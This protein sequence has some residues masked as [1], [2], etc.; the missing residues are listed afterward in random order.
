[1]STGT[2]SDAQAPVIALKARNAF[3]V[4]CA[5]IFV[6]SHRHLSGNQKLF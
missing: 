4:G 6:Y 2:V 3:R 1:V 5:L